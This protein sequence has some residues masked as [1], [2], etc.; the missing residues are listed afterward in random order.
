MLVL[1]PLEVPTKG[2]KMLVTSL[3]A[4]GR[5]TGTMNSHGIIRGTFYHDGK[6]SKPFYFD[7][8][9]STQ[10]G[11]YGGADQF[12]FDDNPGFLVEMD[13]KRATPFY[14]EDGFD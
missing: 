4:S 5:V 13:M 11:N 10:L 1:E 7:L 6:P 2:D 9:S 14:P 8:G 3:S 12:F